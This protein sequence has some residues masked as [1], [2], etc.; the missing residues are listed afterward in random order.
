MPL[1]TPLTTFG[2]LARDHLEYEVSCRI[3]EMA[4]REPIH[5]LCVD[6]AGM[7]GFPIVAIGASVGGLD[8]V[9]VITEALP[10]TCG[11]AVL[12]VM[13]IGAR[14]SDLPEILS[15]HGKLPAAF[16]R[17][18]DR[19]DTGRLYVAP[20]D[21]HMMLIAP[22]VVHLDAGP[23]VHNTRPAV[24]PL[25]MSAAATFGPRVVGVV[26]S[27]R[28]RDGAEGL[29]TIKQLGGMALAEDP[30]HAADGAMPA[31]AIASDDPEILPIDRLAKRVAQFCSGL[32]V[33]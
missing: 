17:E 19:L 31:A 22:G 27:G 32:N 29:R 2:D 7:S 1:A 10:R 18:G 14:Q 28:G 16:A 6:M 33:A 8:A 11:A 12:L 20:P 5:T 13:H 15:W 9:R 24:D 30:A 25:F 26:L 4:A 3:W 23:K 21:R